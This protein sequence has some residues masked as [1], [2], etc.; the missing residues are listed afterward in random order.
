MATKEWNATN[1]YLVNTT[2]NTNTG[3]TVSNAFNNAVPGL[4]NLTTGASAVIQ[5]LL[6]GTPSPDEARLENAWYGAGT[7]LDANSDFLRNRGFD[8]YGKKAAANKQQGLSDLFS[9]LSAT[10]PQAQADVANQQFLQSQA[11]QE[12]QF[13]RNLGQ[14]AA[15]SNRA[16]D[17]QELGLRLQYGNN[18]NKYPGYDM[19]YGRG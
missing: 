3:S 12:S 1:P 17:L 10:N 11:Q 15:A 4:R 14:Q 9:Y 7:G 18:G 6:S 5:N 19:F 2:N 13:G 16:A 8:L